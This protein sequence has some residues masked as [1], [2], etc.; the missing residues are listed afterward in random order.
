MNRLSEAY[1]KALGYDKMLAELDTPSEPQPTA[2]TYIVK[3]KNGSKDMEV[4]FVKFTALQG[5]LVRFKDA[6][7]DTEWRAAT[8]KNK[9]YD[10]SLTVTG[11]R[12]YWVANAL[13]KAKVSEF[14]NVLEEAI[15]GTKSAADLPLSGFTLHEKTD[16]TILWYGNKHI[17]ASLMGHMNGRKKLSRFILDRYIPKEA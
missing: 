2:I 12:P 10:G 4:K 16:R 6:P 14:L 1:L 9:L 13:T 17:Q 3:S 8:V 15:K 11:D 7:K 5:V